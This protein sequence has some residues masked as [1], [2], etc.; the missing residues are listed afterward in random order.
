MRPATQ[1]ATATA[2]ANA[3]SRYG[4]LVNTMG[5]SRNVLRIRPPM[6]FAIEHADLL[7]ST[8]DDVLAA[9]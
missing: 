4:V 1:Q 2:I 3:M 8:L 6:P 7:L 5:P 9:L